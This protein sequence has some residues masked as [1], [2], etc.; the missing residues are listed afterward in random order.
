[1]PMHIVKLTIRNFKRISAVEIEPDGSLVPVR[2]SSPIRHL[3]QGGV[4]VGEL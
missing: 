2:G 3:L 1:M 4:T